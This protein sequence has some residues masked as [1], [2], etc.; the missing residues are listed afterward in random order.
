MY[1]A[2]MEKTCCEIRYRCVLTDIQMPVMDGITAA[3]LILQHFERFKQSNPALPKLWIAA[4]SAY[5][6]ESM[7]EHCR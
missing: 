2:N 1:L 5:S 6:D 7:Q 4:V 3:T